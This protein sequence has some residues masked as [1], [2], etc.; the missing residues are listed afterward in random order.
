M[1]LTNQKPISTVFINNIES[2]LSLKVVRDEKIFVES[3]RIIRNLYCDY[4]ALVLILFSL[5]YG[6][7]I[8]GLKLAAPVKS[9]V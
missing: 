9:D 8:C 4:Y 1:L 5:I 3:K 6:S 2:D 7:I